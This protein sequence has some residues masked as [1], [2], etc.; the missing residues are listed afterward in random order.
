MFRRDKG[1]A[2]RIDAHGITL[3]QLQTLKERLL[4]VLS[5]YLTS[6]NRNPT[7]ENRETALGAIDAIQT[8]LNVIA[9]KY[10]LV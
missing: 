4:T 6:N 2:R 5:T 9:I 7:T 10:A 3:A 1:T 8:E